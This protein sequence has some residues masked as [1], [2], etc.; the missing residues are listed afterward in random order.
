MRLA[1]CIPSLLLL[2]LLL[3]LQVFKRISMLAVKALQHFNHLQAAHTLF[4]PPAAAAGGT[5]PAAV[6]SSSSSS[7]DGVGLEAL[8]LWLAAFQDLFSR[9]CDISGKVVTW[10]PGTAA[11]L[12]PYVRPYW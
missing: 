3:L 11:P 2:L 7:G 4:S 1:F 5:D 12:P 8:L 10:A 9:P 6:S